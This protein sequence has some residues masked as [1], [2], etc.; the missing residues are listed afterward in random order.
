MKIAGVEPNPQP[1]P[2]KYTWIVRAGD[3]TFWEI[4][5][6]LTPAGWVWVARFRE[7]TTSTNSR[8]LFQMQRD[9]ELRN[10][11]DVTKQITEKLGQLHVG[12]K[13]FAPP[14]E[15]GRPRTY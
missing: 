7:Q 2:T 12:S 15:P 11:D 6:E 10:I 4:E 9:D 14:L 5:S 8:I 3:R 1:Q 13:P